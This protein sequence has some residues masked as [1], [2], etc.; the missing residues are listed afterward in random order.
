MLKKILITLS[1]ITSVMATEKITGD[2]VSNTSPPFIVRT[3]NEELH[4]NSFPSIL[5]FKIPSYAS[6]KDFMS[7]R[8][9]IKNAT[10]HF[11]NHDTEYVKDASFYGM[12]G[13]LRISKKIG[14][15]SNDFVTSMQSKKAISIAEIQKEKNP[16]LLNISYLPYSPFSNSIIK[17]SLFL[18]DDYE[19]YSLIPK[20]MPNSNVLEV[21]YRL[22]NQLPELPLPEVIGHLKPSCFERQLPEQKA[23]ESICSYIRNGKLSPKQTIQLIDTLTD[24]LENLFKQ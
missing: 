4:N 18:S 11:K 14:E 21:Y 2:N 10:D 13:L 7:T 9:I 17:L 16:L 22:G 1:S 19:R 15:F 23:L 5:C 8:N 24:H 6:I 12:N 20:K 3:N